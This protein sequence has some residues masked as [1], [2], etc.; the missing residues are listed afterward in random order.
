MEQPCYKMEVEYYRNLR[1]EH[2]TREVFFN[3]YRHVMFAAGYSNRNLEALA[4]RLTRA[5]RDYD[6]AFIAVDPYQ[7]RCAALGVFNPEGKVGAI[8]SMAEYRAHNDWGKF[9]DA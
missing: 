8:V 1:P 3:E 6:I 4:P 7:I 5:F 9:K 2:V